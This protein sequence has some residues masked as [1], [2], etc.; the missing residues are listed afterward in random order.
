[1]EIIPAPDFPPWHHLRH[2][3]KDGYRTGRG[4][5]I[6]RASAILSIDRGQRKP[7]SLMSYP[8][9]STKTLQERMASWSTRKDRRHQPSRTVNKSGMPD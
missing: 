1:M 3:V 5:V 2:H 6:M 7:S 8:T 4:R 9:K